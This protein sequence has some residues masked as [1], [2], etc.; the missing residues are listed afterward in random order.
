MQGTAYLGP[1]MQLATNS[2]KA[3]RLQ[4]RDLFSRSKNLHLLLLLLPQ[5][6]TVAVA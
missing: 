5:E 2:S 1:G 6:A 4:A 3:L